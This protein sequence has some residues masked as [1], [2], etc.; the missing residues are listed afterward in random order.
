MK[1]DFDAIKQTYYSLV[2]CCSKRRNAIR[3]P[4]VG[5]CYLL[6]SPSM[7]GIV[8]FVASI[9]IIVAVATV[10][11]LFI[12]ALKPQVEFFARGQDELTW[13]SWLL[14]V[15]AVLMESI[16][17][18]ALFLRVVYSKCQKRI[19][20]ETMKKEGRWKEE[21]IE[22]SLA[23]DV[24][25]CRYGFFV[26]LVTFPLNLIPVAGTFL[27]AFLNAPFNAWDYM[28]M[29]FDAIQMDDRAQKLEV[30]GGNLET[31]CCGMYASSEYV[32]FGFVSV[33]L[34]TIPILGPAVFSLSNACGAAL[35]ACDMEANGGP[36]TTRGKSTSTL[37]NSSRRSYG[38]V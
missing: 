21:M 25:C 24:N 30:S 10:T 5:F 8:C 19:F 7:W 1:G 13:W 38:N 29:Y 23:K 31:H 9:G 15:I 28:D 27:Y 18:C 14:G 34:E 22:P 2:M 33:L 20:V 6:T 11:V 4:I 16:A 35:W 12:F 37:M 32:R 36:P 26:G 3:Y 17:L